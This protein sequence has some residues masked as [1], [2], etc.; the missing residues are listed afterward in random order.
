MPGVVCR[1]VKTHAFLLCVRPDSVHQRSAVHRLNA[2]PANSDRC[3]FLKKDE[4]DL[5]LLTLRHADA[6]L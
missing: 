6:V 5:L 3:S 1:I 4:H 2:Q